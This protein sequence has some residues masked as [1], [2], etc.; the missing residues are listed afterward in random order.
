[1]ADVTAAPPRACGLLNGSQDSS[2][3]RLTLLPA[4]ADAAAA[5]A[6][7]DIGAFHARLGQRVVRHI[8]WISQ[9]FPL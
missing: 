2:R 8:N 6:T 1:M 5:A 4:D 7:A 9:A 3:R